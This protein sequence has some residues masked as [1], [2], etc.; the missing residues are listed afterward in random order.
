MVRSFLVWT[1]SQKN[2]VQWCELVHSWERNTPHQKFDISC[3]VG[4][5]TTNPNGVRVSVST[6]HSVARGRALRVTKKAYWYL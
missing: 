4:K 2:F 6:L 1:R 5:L 3:S